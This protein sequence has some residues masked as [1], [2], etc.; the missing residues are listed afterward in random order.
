MDT[1]SA[2]MQATSA[3][4]S[5]FFIASTN[6][7]PADLALQEDHVPSILLVLMILL[8]PSIAIFVGVGVWIIRRIKAI[9]IPDVESKFSSPRKP[10]LGSSTEKFNRKLSEKEQE[11]GDMSGETTMNGTPIPTIRVISK[12]PS[13]DNE[14]LD[15]DLEKLDFAEFSPNATSTLP[16]RVKSVREAIDE[17]VKP[18]DDKKA[19]EDDRSKQQSPQY[20][21]ALS[22]FGISPVFSQPKDAAPR[23]LVDDRYPSVRN[24]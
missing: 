20:A 11:L 8:L 18:K 23:G 5:V 7:P 24:F 14:S 12:S 1:S 22:S 2:T 10:T 13:R 3:S 4:P 15:V 9:P 16:R 6:V 21:D 17:L 19:E